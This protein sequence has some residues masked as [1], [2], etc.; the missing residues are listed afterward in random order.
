MFWH[1]M[2]NM[3]SLPKT[4]VWFSN[5]IWNKFLNKDQTAY[6]MDI[7]AHYQKYMKK[8]VIKILRKLSRNKFW[9]ILKNK[10]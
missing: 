1:P 6:W 5:E 2:A 10:N 9:K 8:F 7:R 3:L 4:Y